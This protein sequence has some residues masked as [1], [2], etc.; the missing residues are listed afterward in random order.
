M[1][2]AP[3][4]PLVAVVGD[5][6][7]VSLPSS[8][9]LITARLFFEA[10]LR[11]A[12][13]ARVTSSSR[14]ALCRDTAFVAADLAAAFAAGRFLVWFSLVTLRGCAG[15]FVFLRGGGTTSTGSLWL[16]LRCFVTGT[17]FAVDY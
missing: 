16:V 5:A 13:T 1:G 7:P 3:V 14:C 2:V 10:A 17:S 11:F 8:S 9:S 6:V 4:F 15:F 12:M